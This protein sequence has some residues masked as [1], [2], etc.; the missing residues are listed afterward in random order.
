MSHDA[1]AV[2]TTKESHHTV[3]KGQITV[4]KQIE[5]TVTSIMIAP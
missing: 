5:F 2:I 4:A 1:H 3:I